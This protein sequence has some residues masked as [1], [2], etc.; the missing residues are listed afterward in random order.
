MPNDTNPFHDEQLS[1]TYQARRHRRQSPNESIEKPIFLQ[2]LGNVENK[3]ILDL[4]CGDG[5][6]GQELF[7]LGCQSYL[8]LE[9]SEPM[10]QSARKNLSAT[11]GQ[12][13]HTKIEDWD[14]PSERFHIVISRLA[15]HYVADLQET[16]AN[17]HR[18]LKQN[19]RFIFSIVHPVITSSDKS[20][21]KGGMRQDWIV[22]EYFSVGERQVYFMGE[23]VMQYHRP[24]E[25]IYSALQNADFQIEHLRESRP[26]RE[27]F[28][29]EAQYERRKRIPLFLFLASRKA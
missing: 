28:N 2:L 23:K 29:D 17:V 18:T 27:N 26:E 11:S 16:F 20:R 13:I 19:G 21:A 12:V 14:Y 22:D 8:G 10:V 6:F 7:D 3:R 24:I 15:L 1:D 25:D 9:S 4:G 5:K